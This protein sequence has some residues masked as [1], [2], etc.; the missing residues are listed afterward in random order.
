[1]QLSRQRPEESPKPCK[2]YKNESFLNGPHAR[3]LRIQCEFEEPRVRLEEHKIENIVMIFGSARSKAPDEYKK[4]LDELTE[5]AKTDP[6][7]KPQLVRA[8]R[9]KFLCR[10]HD[11]TVRLA[12]IIT[13]FSMKRQ[14]EGLP[15]YTVGTG[16][17]PGMMEAANEGAWRA[18]GSSCGFGISLPFETGLNPYVTPELGF[19]FH[20]FFT[21]KFWMAYKCM[22]LVVAPGGY[23]TCDELFEI[24]TLIQNMK[25]KHKPPVILFGKEYWTEVLHFDVMEEYGL[26]GP[27]ARE[28]VRTCDTA[29]EALEILKQFWLERERNGLLLSPGKRKT[30]QQVENGVKRFR[31]NPD[32][33]PERP[34]PPK[35]YKNLDF[36]KSSHSRVFRI[37]CEFEETRTRLEAQGI[38]NTLMFSGSGSVHTYAEHLAAF[39]EAAKDPVRNAAELARL[40]K[41]QPLLQYHQVSRDLA[42]RITAWSME[43]AKRGKTS[44]HVSTGGACGLVESANEGAWEAGGKSLAFSDDVAKTFNKYVTPELAFN[45]HYFFTQKFW[46]A[47]KC[48]GLVALP[49]G[50]GTCDEVFELLTLMQTGK[51]KQKL[52]VVLIG[53]DY[54]K[55]SIKWQKMADYGMISDF[56]VQ[57]L[58]FTDSADAAFDH[59][60]KFWERNEE[61]NETAG[62]VG[63]SPRRKLTPC[64]SST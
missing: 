49:G 4:N 41:Q 59:I 42:R 3:L 40:A 52:P 53:E 20:Y 19:E 17:G 54:W 24:L 43:R 37:Q 63:A 22:G 34:M 50:F 25:I 21:R 38:S 64:V 28:L 2:A 31:L 57:Q 51:M 29:D 55:R 46:I 36:I 47:Y 10:Y 30:P 11:E 14:A 44:Y 39:A 58:L 1:M 6:T 45:F 62:L 33:V 9:M 35:A 8:E 26:I 18:G 7:V 32:E 13:E 48:M 56:D 60:I 15:S 5:K 23:G 27:D 61:R 16:A 12:K